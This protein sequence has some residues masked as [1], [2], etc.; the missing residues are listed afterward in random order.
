MKYLLYPLLF[1]RELHLFP[2]KI[3]KYR[4]LFTF[5]SHVIRNIKGE[6][7]QLKL[8]FIFP[9]VIMVKIKICL[10]NLCFKT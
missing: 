9:S 1:K 10:I 5:H 8:Y 4:L 7:C 6:I 3:V 2:R